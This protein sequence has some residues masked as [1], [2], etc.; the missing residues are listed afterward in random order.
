MA[1]YFVFCVCLEQSHAQKKISFQLS[2]KTCLFSF[3]ARSGFA[4]EHNVYVNRTLSMQLSSNGMRSA[5]DS[6]NTMSKSCEL[7]SIRAWRS[8]S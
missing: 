4:I 3:K 1:S 8:I 7:A 6:K 5:P 2:L